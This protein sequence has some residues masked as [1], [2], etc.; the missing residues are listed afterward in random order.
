M[1]IV[2]D[3]CACV[4]WVVVGRDEWLLLTLPTLSRDEDQRV[5]DL[6]MS[7]NDGVMVGN[8]VGGLRLMV[9]W[10]RVVKTMCGARKGLV[11]LGWVT[12]AWI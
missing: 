12:M 9:R 5:P 4:E 10:V 2:R 3:V 8:G 1:A 6:I 7:G 11:G